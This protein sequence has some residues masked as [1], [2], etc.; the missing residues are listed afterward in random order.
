MDHAGVAPDLLAGGYTATKGVTS[1]INYTDDSNFVITCIGDTNWH[2]SKP[3][4][5][6]TVVNGGLTIDQARK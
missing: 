3:D 2:L 1:S 4:A 5:T 6:Y